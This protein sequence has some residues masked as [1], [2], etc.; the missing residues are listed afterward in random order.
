MLIILG[1]AVLSIVY[2]IRFSIAEYNAW[3]SDGFSI[4]AFTFGFF[5]V[6]TLLLI[7]INRYSIRANIAGFEAV[8][9]TLIEA[10]ANASILPY[11]LAAI[12]SRA[13]GDNA[14]LSR[15]QYWAANPFLN[16]FIPKEIMNIKP[17]R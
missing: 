1:L 17:I 14:W 16:W 12:Q 15:N 11:E 6:M 9:A 2:L 13:A 10:R 5:L 3:D 4:G 8:R 7:P